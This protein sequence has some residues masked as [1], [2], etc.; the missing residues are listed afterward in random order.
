M[1]GVI[2]SR[3][4]A[5]A[6]P[7]KALNFSSGKHFSHGRG[8]GLGKAILHC[9]NHAGGGGTTAADIKSA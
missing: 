2:F 6:G 3:T 1:G 8:G 7:R 9:K 5:T 4:S